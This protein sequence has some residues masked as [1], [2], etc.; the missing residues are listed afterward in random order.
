M[1]TKRIDSIEEFIEQ[2]KSVSLDTLCDEFQVSKNTIRRD[3]NE[4]VKKGTIRKVYGGVTVNQ[5][6]E[7]PI[8]VPY[9][10]RHDSFMDEKN[11]ICQAAARYV[12][13]GDNIYIDTGTT[14]MNMIDYISD[15]NCTIITN[16]LQICWKAVPYPNLR[17]IVLPGVLKRETL[18]FVG[19]EINEQLRTYNITKAFMAC[20]GLTLENGVTNASTEEYNIKRAVIKNSQQ[21][22]LL[23]D[24]S[25]FGKASLMTYCNLE[26]FQYI[27][28]DTIPVKKYLTF[29]KELGIIVETCLEKFS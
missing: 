16:S 12:N 7:S 20:T 29:C 3:I 17:I 28:T 8:L 1:R 2:E 25:K 5:S 11:A 22:Y 10:Q 9:Q 26:D 14:C 13:D 18:S 21:H 15:I 24:H 27:I 23:T 19:D 4:L 6:A